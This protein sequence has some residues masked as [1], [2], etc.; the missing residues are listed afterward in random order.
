MCGWPTATVKT[1]Q[2]IQVGAQL[3][4]MKTCLNDLLRLLLLPLA[5]NSLLIGLVHIQLWWF[6]CLCK[7]AYLLFWRECCLTIELLLALRLL[8]CLVHFKVL[9][10][11]K[12]HM[13]KF[14]HWNLGGGAQ[15]GQITIWTWFDIVLFSHISLEFFWLMLITRL[16]ISFNLIWLC[17]MTFNL[18]TPYWIMLF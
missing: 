17:L 3:S 4:L 10:W 1:A 7:I 8:K 12:A 11:I 9:W 14:L 13:I 2:L 6:P 18:R 5:M 15:I 16:F